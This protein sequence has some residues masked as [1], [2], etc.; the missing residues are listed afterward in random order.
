MSTNLIR[1][2]QFI[3]SRTFI[4]EILCV[5]QIIHPEFGKRAHGKPYLVDYPEF[6]FNLSHCG[7]NDQLAVAVTWGLDAD[8]GLDMEYTD[9]FSNKLGVISKM[10][11]K[12]FGGEEIELVRELSCKDARSAS[13]LFLYLWTLKESLCKCTGQGIHQEV[14]RAA[15]PVNAEPY[16]LGIGLVTNKVNP[17]SGRDALVRVDHPQL[18][19]W[20]GDEFKQYTSVAMALPWDE[21]DHRCGQGQTTTFQISMGNRGQLEKE[22]HL[23]MD[24]DH[25][26]TRGS[27]YLI[28]SATLSQSPPIDHMS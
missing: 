1:K 10:A 15:R 12:Y 8:I 19:Y 2:Q 6:K 11:D 25:N 9:R 14:F 20:Q 5:Y 27:P 7:D 4:S 22:S 17:V 21:N 3:L 24:M 28:V 13:E 16:D 18:V 23:A 26:F